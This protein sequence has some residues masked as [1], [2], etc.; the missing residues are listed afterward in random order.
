MFE[1]HLTP[2][3]PGRTGADAVEFLFTA[4]RNAAPRPIEK[5]ASGGELSRVMLAIKALLASRMQL[6]TIIFDEID[7]GVSGR[8]ADAMGDIIA[9]LSATMQVIDITHLPQVASKGAAH[10][11]VSK[12]DGRTAIARLTDDERVAEIAKMLSG[13]TV[14]DAAL[15]QA[16]ILL[17]K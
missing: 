17:G 13:N 11:V 14:T 16:R 5:I 9:Q 3:E 2:T 6:P 7:T 8:I 4:N 10:F 12:H 1:A 15:A